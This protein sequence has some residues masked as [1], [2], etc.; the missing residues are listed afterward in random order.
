MQYVT[1]NPDDKHKR[2]YNV[3]RVEHDDLSITARCNDGN[4]MRA[5][6]APTARVPY[7]YTSAIHVLKTFVACISR[8]GSPPFC[9]RRR[10]HR[11]GGGG[12]HA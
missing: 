11:R 7:K 6:N 4:D 3:E 1:F 5:D 9:D 10:R 8:M 2:R 12:P